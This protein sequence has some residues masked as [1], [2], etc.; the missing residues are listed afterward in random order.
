MR[1]L[2][3]FRLLGVVTALA[4]AAPVW[5]QELPK[6]EPL[7]GGDATG[8]TVLRKCSA[9]PPLPTNRP[10]TQE[11]YSA[12]MDALEC[13]EYLGGA[14]DQ[15]YFWD[16]MGPTRRFCQP[17]GATIQ[18]LQDAV[19]AYLKAHP[20]RQTLPLG[21]AIAEA[22]VQSYPCVPPLQPAAAAAPTPCSS[23]GIVPDPVPIQQYQVDRLKQLESVAKGREGSIF[24]QQYIEYGN[25]LQ[26]Q[27][28]TPEQVQIVASATGYSVVGSSTG[29]LYRFVSASCQSVPQR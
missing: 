2:A 5:S 8:A 12:E 11:E 14:F 18:T 20:D 21:P 1:N 4:I 15:A 9:S 22:L 29:R 24:W 7:F 28:T 16:G 13:V 26:R 3:L 23:D 25:E 17:S 19:I 6:A 27:R 10:L